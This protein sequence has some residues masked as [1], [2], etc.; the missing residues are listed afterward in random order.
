[1]TDPKPLTAL[2]VLDERANTSSRLSGERRSA[3]KCAGDPVLTCMMSY[4]NGEAIAYICASR[5]ME[6]ELR[7]LCNRFQNGI[8][9]VDDFGVV[10]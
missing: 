2:Q 7:R 3:E 8:L 9:S 5:V 6:A 4:R 10:L 1:M